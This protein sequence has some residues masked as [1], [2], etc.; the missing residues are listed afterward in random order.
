MK[1]STR[2]I[3]RLERE[4][5]AHNLSLKS[6]DSDDKTENDNK[7]IEKDKENINK[8][9][10]KWTNLVK[11]CE[12]N[13]NVEQQII[14]RDIINETNKKRYWSNHKT[15]KRREH[16]EDKMIENSRHYSKSKSWKY[17]E[18][19]KK[20]N[21][22]DMNL[23]RRSDYAERDQREEQTMTRKQ[24]KVSSKHKQRDETQKKDIQNNNL[25]R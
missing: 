6:E 11:L 19:L 2:F 13:I 4:N 25:Q 15:K 16:K 22:D 5:K 12:D 7:V 18:T 14:S 8:C 23:Q 20:K 10:F 3:E 21:N 1:M 17:E 24:S 9:A